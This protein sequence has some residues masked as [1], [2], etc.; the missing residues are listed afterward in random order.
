MQSNYTTLSTLPIRSLLVFFFIEKSE[1]RRKGCVLVK[2]ANQL[3]SSSNYGLLRRSMNF[4]R[5]HFANPRKRSEKNFNTM[6][7]LPKIMSSQGKPLMGTEYTLGTHVNHFKC[8][9]CNK[10]FHMN[11]VVGHLSGNSHRLKY[12]VSKKNHIKMAT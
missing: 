8:V 10:S 11:L 7:D 5:G 6:E 9:L 1:I 4:N 3:N 2:M 12:C